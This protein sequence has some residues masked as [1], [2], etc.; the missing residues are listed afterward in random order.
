M[1]QRLVEYNI[2]KR[3]AELIKKLYDGM[4]YQAQGR[5]HCRCPSSHPTSVLLI[6]RWF[7]PP[8]SSRK[9]RNI[10]LAFIGS[11]VGGIG[12]ALSSRISETNGQ[13]SDDI[14]TLARL[15]SL[16]VVPA[17]AEPLATAD[18]AFSRAFPPMATTRALSSSPSIFRNP[19]CRKPSALFHR[20]L[21]F[22]AGPSTSG[23]LVTERSSRED[24]RHAGPPILPSLSAQL[25]TALF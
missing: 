25:A 8:V 1:S 24:K 3:E 20:P 13:D 15:P 7:L 22:S 6:R 4:A 23:I 5:Q 18:V 10:R 11:L 21:L 9:A 14:E 17:F 2:L 16:A 12:L 19:K